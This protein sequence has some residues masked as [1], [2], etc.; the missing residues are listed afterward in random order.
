M[1][2]DF[3]KTQIALEY[4]RTRSLVDPV[5]WIR[6]EKSSS[7][8]QDYGRISSILKRTSQDASTQYDDEEILRRSRLSLE[9]LD[10]FLLVLDNADDLDRFTGR[11]P[12]TRNLSSYLPG[13]GDVLITTRDPRFL[14]GFAPGRQGKRVSEFARSD[15][16]T[17]L[18][19]S[20][21]SHLA[22]T[23]LHQDIERLLDQLGDLPLAIAQAAANVN[24]LQIDLCTYISAYDDQKERSQVMQAPFCDNEAN[25]ERNKLQSVY[26]TWD[27]SFNFLEKEHKPSAICLQLMTLYHWSAIPLNILASLS[28][29]EAMTR[30]ELRNV[31]KRL[32]HLSLIKENID[33]GI[34]EY[35]LHRVVH[36]VIL[37]RMKRTSAETLRSM[38]IN[39]SQ[40]LVDRFP[41]VAGKDDS[42]QLF[43]ARYLLP[44]ALRQSQLLDEMEIFNTA[45]ARLLQGVGNYLAESKQSKSA[46]YFSS[47][48]LDVAGQVWR[49]DDVSVLYIRRTYAE[50]LVQDAKYAEAETVTL[51]C[52]NMLEM[53]NISEN[54][55]ERNLLLVKLSIAHLHDQSLF[56]QS[57][58]HALATAYQN[59]IDLAVRT[60]FSRRQ[61]RTLQSNV[62]NNLVEIG[63][64]AEA[65]QINDDLIEEITSDSEN[66]KASLTFYGVVLNVR[67]KILR[68]LIRQS[69]VAAEKAQLEAEEFEI[70]KQVLN[71]SIEG[72]GIESLDTWKATNNLLEKFISRSQ[73]VLC[74]SLMCQILRLALETDI[75]IQGQFLETFSIFASKVL[76]IFSVVGA[77]PSKSVSGLHRLFDD[78]LSEQSLTID[79]LDIA[80]AAYNSMGV[81]LQWSGQFEEAE[82]CLKRLLE[83]EDLS[84]TN[85]GGVPHYNL[86]LAIAQQS[87]R[88][89]EAFRYR[90][91]HRSAI[92]D[93]EVQHGSLE[94]RIERWETEGQ[95]YA[96]SK[97]RILTGDSNW[98]SEWCQAHK[99]ELCR[100]QT[101]WGW[102][103]EAINPWDETPIVNEEEEADSR[104]QN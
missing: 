87:G 104:I 48:A 16:R 27:I 20:V 80:P 82:A 15:A 74:V 36:E 30:F 79:D 22:D 96:E 52:M 1:L 45:R 91:D 89:A 62:A 46:T 10:N 90:I 2:I 92:V 68:D 35:S 4:A 76:L 71:Y 94:K 57:K 95:L 42:S 39:V 86:M 70:R 8:G 84:K 19:S 58:Y 85:L 93:E 21:P 38:L 31:I 25:D 103:Y 40:H 41:F 17:L 64:S 13:K 26:I 59:T 63:R 51:E 49:P 61:M 28:Y 54:L 55:G 81:Y 75:C 50:S 34:V 14:G 99:E 47:Q 32:L 102:L 7:F 67:A 43:L 60:G 83:N 29:F 66:F 88:L 3:S 11:L 5:F 53:Q 100:A 78:L 69:V 12:N 6:C 18:L 56:G 44:H 24:E 9:E 97:S 77:T 72:G 101:R 23:A 98:E 73:W 37:D 33:D 65:R